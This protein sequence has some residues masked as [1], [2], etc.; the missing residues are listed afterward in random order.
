MIQVKAFTL[1]DRAT[2]RIF[3]QVKKTP[4]ETVISLLRPTA[5]TA[6]R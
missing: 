2:F 6:C 5:R 3:L 4:A 1:R